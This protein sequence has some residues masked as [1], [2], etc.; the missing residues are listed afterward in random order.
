MKK[1]TVDGNEFVC[2]D[3][4]SKT[5]NDLIDFIDCDNDIEI[6]EFNPVGEVVLVNEDGKIHY[7]EIESVDHDIE[8][9]IS[10]KDGDQGY[11][12]LDEIDFHDYKVIK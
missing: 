11:Y 6:E 2:S 5:I 9:S 12:D 4:I 1:V 3:K 8:F 7:G 10:F